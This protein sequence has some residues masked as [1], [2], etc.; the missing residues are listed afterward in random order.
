MDIDHFNELFLKA[1]AALQVKLPP[2]LPAA[3]AKGWAPGAAEKLTQMG[4]KPK[5]VSV[6]TL[7]MAM[8][9]LYFDEALTSAFRDEL[10]KIA[11]SG[12]LSEELLKIAKALMSPGAFARVAESARESGG[13]LAQKAEQALAKAKLRSA[14]V[15]TEIGMKSLVGGMGP[16]GKVGT[17]PVVSMRSIR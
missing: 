9:D 17:N 15:P 1:A 3:A 4:I 14:P 16:V 12:A 2:R 11:S 5:A 7:K 8:S 13:T 6:G 10:Q